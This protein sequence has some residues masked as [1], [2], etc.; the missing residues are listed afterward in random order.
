MTS[1]HELLERIVW[2]SIQNARPLKSLLESLGINPN[3][4]IS[5][6]QLEGLPLTQEIWDVQ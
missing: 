1:G 3:V 2:H 5:I 4:I 6:K